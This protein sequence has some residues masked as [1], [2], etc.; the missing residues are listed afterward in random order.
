MRT[1]SENEQTASRDEIADLAR[2]LWERGGHQSGRD[3]EYWLQAERDVLARR[4]GP[5]STRPSAATSEE[6][7][8]TGGP[9][10]LLRSTAKTVHI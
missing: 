5:S 6:P 4:N 9:R 8:A 7:K 3:L 10:K 1:T 2:Q